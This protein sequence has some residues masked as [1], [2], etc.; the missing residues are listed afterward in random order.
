MDDLEE[1]RVGVIGI[2][3]DLTFRDRLSPKVRSS[4]CERTI[5]FPHYD[6]NELRKVLNQRANVAFKADALRRHPEVRSARHPGIGRRT[7]RA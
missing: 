7:P 4:L 3:N 5:S 1:A 2:S 6:A